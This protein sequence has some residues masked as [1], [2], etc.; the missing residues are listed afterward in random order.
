M[1]RGPV[2]AVVAAA[3]LL[4]LAGCADIPTSGAVHTPGPVQDV[5]NQDVVLVPYPPA[6]NAAPADIVQGFI[7]AATGQQGDYAIARK[8]LTPALAKRWQPDARV[9][10]HDQ[11]WQVKIESDT[12]IEVTVPTTAEV[13]AEGV[14]TGYATAKDRAVPFRLAKVNGQWRIASTPD[15]IVLGT[16]YFGSL[17]TARPVSFFDPAWT[18]AVPD[19]RWF[20]ARRIT[21]TGVVQAL[22]AGQSPPIAA[23][24][25]ATAFPAGT[26][27][28]SVKVAAGVAT[29]DLDTGNVVPSLTVLRRMRRQ[30]TD[31]L[32]NLDGI[33]QVQVAIDGTAM[34]VPPI[35]QSAAPDP[36]P[37]V[38]SGTEVGNLTDSKLA[39]EPVLGRQVAAA[40]PLG[41]TISVS[42]RIAALRTKAGVAL[43]TPSRTTVVDRRAGLIDP[44]LDDYGWVYSVPAGDPTAWKAFDS[45]GD[46]VAVT[47]SMPAGV[48][49]VTAIEA[50]RDGTRMLVLA[51]TQAGPTAFVAGIL[52]DTVGAPIALTTDRY[53]VDVPASSTALDATWVD[54]PGSSVAVLTQDDTGESVS[55]QQ[56][57]GLPS[58]AGRLSTA[59][60]IVGATTLKDLRALLQNGAIGE[61]SGSVW[62]SV[63]PAGSADVLFV[64]R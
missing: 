5:K 2:A 50:S 49:S 47:V 6:Q 57:G 30:L 59:E 19:L 4:L 11:S 40:S 27:I 54:A 1:R 45:R 39:D 13:D 31:S 52:R 8:F 26:T 33:Q 60:T 28:T 48:L 25:T 61:L 22:L 10:I 29:V 23:P 41:G 34:P 62:Q 32:Q 9:L 20:P 42:D 14:Y 18:S 58:S 3:L 55:V 64:Q 63:E 12:S 46:T 17:F 36:R 7:T 43:V 21:P 37:L 53:L 16:N 35:R 51:D 44:A 24:V 56:L 38:L 15:G